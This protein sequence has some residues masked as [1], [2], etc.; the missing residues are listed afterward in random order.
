VGEDGHTAASVVADLVADLGVGRGTIMAAVRDFG[1]PGPSNARRPLGHIAGHTV[2]SASVGGRRAA[3]RAGTRP[4]IAPV[5][6]AA[7][8]PPAHAV[9]GMTTAQCLAL[10]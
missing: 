8:M 5:A 4:A 9:V 10:A 1:S 7:A 2:R 6:I 3:R